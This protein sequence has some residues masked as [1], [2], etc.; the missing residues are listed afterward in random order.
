MFYVRTTAR[1]NEGIIFR[2]HHATHVFE[3]ERSALN[4][5]TKLL[6][7]YTVT[8]SIWRGDQVLGRSSWPLPGITCTYIS[9]VPVGPG[10]ETAPVVAGPGP[11]FTRHTRSLLTG[12][13]QCPRLAI[14]K[15]VVVQGLDRLRS[16]FIL[17]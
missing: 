10:L 7:P 15:Y 13:S 14:D 9:R 4:L 6:T 12:P 1:A 2:G 17:A 8:V 16:R 3:P 11:L 5:I